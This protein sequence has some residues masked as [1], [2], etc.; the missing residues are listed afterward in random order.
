MRF[1]A[2]RH[3]RTRVAFGLTIILILAAALRLYRLDSVPPGF[4]FD[5][6]YN[7]IDAIGVLE[8]EWRIFFPANGGREPLYTYWQA[9]LFALLGQ[10]LFALRVASALVGVLTLPLAFGAIRYLF[11]DHP[12][13]NALGL[14]TA[15]FMAISFWHLHFSHY[16]I[17][18]VLLPPI[19]LVTFW[20]FWYGQATG[21][22]WAFAAAGVGL[23]AG[24]YA[25]PA[26]R[27]LP[28]LL[29]LFSAYDVIAAR[30]DFRRQLRGLVVAGLVSFLL[31]LPLGLYFLKH[32]WLFTGHPGAVSVLDPRVNKGDLPGTL[33]RH[34]LQLAGMFLWRGD[35]AW[36][37]NLPGRP[38]FDL[39]SGAA[40]LAGV[41][42]WARA[43]MRPRT[44]DRSPPQSD[45]TVVST[46]PDTV[47]SQRSAVVLDRRPHAYLALWIG[48]MVLPSLLSDN[49]PNFSRAIGALPAICVFPALGL[50]AIN[51][52]L[53]KRSR[54]ADRQPPPSP[55]PSRGSLSFAKPKGVREGVWPG[56][57]LAS[58]ILLV[59]GAW[60]ARDY[61]IRF[62]QDPQAY[63][64]YDGDKGDV[65]AILADLV[66]RGQVYMAPPWAKHATVDF[67]TRGWEIKEVALGPG[68]VI[69]TPAS[70]RDAYYVIRAEDLSESS[71]VRRRL[72]PAAARWLILDRYGQPLIFVHHLPIE[73]VPDA[74]PPPEHEARVIFGNLFELIGYTVDSSVRAGDRLKAY[75]FWRSLQPAPLNYTQ[76]LHLV[77]QAGRRWGQVDREPL[78]GTYGTSEWEPGEV[79]IDRLRFVVD[80]CAPPGTYRLL[81]GWYDAQTGQRVPVSR[82]G[83]TAWELGQVQLARGLSPEQVAPQHRLQAALTKGIS[84]LGYD[85]RGGEL[86]AGDSL[87]L[88]LYWQPMDR[89]D[90]ELEF[91]VQMRELGMGRVAVLDRW[92]PGV[93]TS[94]WRPGQV[95]CD[96]REFQLPLNLSRGTY[97]LEVSASDGQAVPLEGLTLQVQARSFDLPQPQ[98]SLKAS[99]GDQILLLGYDLGETQV[100]PGET[101][102]L[103]LYWQAQAGMDVSYTVFTHLLD[104]DE[105]IW[106]QVDSIPV[107]GTYPTSDWLPGEV[108]ADEYTIP[109]SPD[110]PPGTY[111]IEV[112]MY[113]AV[114]GARLP[115]HDTAGR[116][117]P[118]GR[119]LLDTTVEVR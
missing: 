75:V 103:T 78:E 117:V 85:G 35:P 32:P 51:D 87:P 55:P 95:F 33:V 61:Y 6:A 102:H 5:E 39:V 90:G 63:Y 30:N 7:A 71:A 18:A 50:V 8:G 11:R 100:A 40:F 23:A 49:P 26:A 53:R 82:G 106:G 42:T 79:I 118:G 12:R 80:P 19:V 47:G 22:L 20:A 97:Q 88:S 104:G 119:V 114:T 107:Q 105:R 76:F 10:N 101:L 64:W 48:I 56:F 77:D 112:G 84:L 2:L 17:R 94:E 14:L 116:P 27:L 109:V 29:I 86:R 9:L 21:R 70:G 58:L 113:D 89:M 96:H 13:A 68:V 46:C 65:V 1:S 54:I 111:V 3:E 93:P 34:T 36:L 59:S 62:A 44:A 110:A 69:P 24:V 57:I 4:Q 43:L 25:H 83:L 41:V 60:T 45:E 91:I 67:L 81:L 15:G 16:A 92:G 28:F 38:V 98:V 31:F 108:V 66:Q 99:L 37:H 74:I 72:G 52:L 115:V 73:A